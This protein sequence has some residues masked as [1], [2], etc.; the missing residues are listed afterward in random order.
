MPRLLRDFNSR[1]G[2]D[3]GAVMTVMHP[4]DGEPFLKDAANPEGG[5]I[6]VTLLGQDS[7]VYSDIVHKQQTKR[8][9]KSIS[10]RSMKKVAD[11]A[12]LERDRMVVLVAC[13]M[14]WDGIED[15]DGKPLPCTDANKKKLYTEC[16]W[17]RDQVD[18][19]ITERSNFLGEA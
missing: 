16:A 3:E 14:S 15:D 17:L 8:L 13:T 7:K 18:E 6:T 10:A 1:Q 4:T 19:F 12:A 2:A 5:A 11:A 9:G